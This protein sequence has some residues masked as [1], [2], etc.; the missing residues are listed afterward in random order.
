[1]ECFEPGFQN[2]LLSITGF[3]SPKLSDVIER[4]FF[5]VFYIFC[6]VVN[7]NEVHIRLVLK[8]KMRFPARFGGKV[9]KKRFD[10]QMMVNSRNRYHM[11]GK[12]YKML[13]PLQPD[14]VP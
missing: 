8:Q 14:M 4:R 13:P 6:D 11:G 9:W 7:E 1:M 3:F 12:N 10:A 5:L 2:C